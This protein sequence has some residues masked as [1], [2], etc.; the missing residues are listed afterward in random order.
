MPSVRFSPS[1]RERLLTSKTAAR[2]GR[3]GGA[4]TFARYG[5]A[6]MQMIGRRGFQVTTDRHFGG[7]R[8]KHLN[9]LI[10]K[11]LRALDPAPWDGAWRNFNERELERSEGRRES[12]RPRSRLSGFAPGRTQPADR[13]PGE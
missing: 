5:R 6:H 8:R 3:K 4:A 10:R 11:G 12:S 13:P 7:D 1:T 9:E 2:F